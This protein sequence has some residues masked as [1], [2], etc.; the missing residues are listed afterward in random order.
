M[1]FKRTELAITI[2]CKVCNTIYAA[3]AIF[4]GVDIDSD[5][6]MI[7]A[8]ADEKGDTVQLIKG[9]EWSFGHCSCD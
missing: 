6:T 7:M 2:T 8:D 9:K 1:E 3:H 4:G 5:F